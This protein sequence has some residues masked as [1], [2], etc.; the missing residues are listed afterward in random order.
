MSYHVEQDCATPVTWGRTLATAVIGH[1]DA[2][3]PGQ[4]RRRYP[5][6]PPAGRPDW[7]QLIRRPPPPGHHLSPIIG[8]LWEHRPPPSLSHRPLLSVIEHTQAG[9]ATRGEVL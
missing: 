6:L 9:P 5:T 8:R 3:Y 1:R 2:V 4:S 7:S